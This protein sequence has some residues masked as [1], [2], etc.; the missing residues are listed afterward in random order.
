[1]DVQL[2]FPNA[3]LITGTNV[4]LRANP[5]KLSADPYSAGWLFRA[6]EAP[7]GTRRLEA[8]A[9]SGAIRG[10][11]VKPWLEQDMERLSRF[12]HARLAMPADGGQFAEGV[13]AHLDRDDALQLV[14]EFF[15]PHATWRT[16]Q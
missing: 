7:H 12:I 14:N 15:P 8:A 4:Y 11:A 3:M 6:E 13:L 16:P 5:S 9:L 1:V 10:E 2:T